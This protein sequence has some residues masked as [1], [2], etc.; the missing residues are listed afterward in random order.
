MRRKEEEKTNNNKTRTRTTR[1]Y[2]LFPCS[3]S[4]D[5][6]LN[7]GDDICERDELVQ[8]RRRR[9]QQVREVA[10]A[11]QAQGAAFLRRAR[12]Q[13]L[14]Q[15]PELGHGAGRVHLERG[16]APAWRAGFRFTF[17]FNARVGE[18]NKNGTHKLII[19]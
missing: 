9:V 5:T 13:A 4:Q 2:L 1:Y 3:L 16:E 6:R 17:S 15:R 14:H 12:R 7:Q 19:S 8:A 11:E 18:N 10:E